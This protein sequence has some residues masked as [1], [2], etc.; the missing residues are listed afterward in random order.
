MHDRLMHD[1]VLTPARMTSRTNQGVTRL[2]SLVG[3][4]G[5]VKLEINYKSTLT[6]TTSR[7]L[8]SGTR[9]TVVYSVVGRRAEAVTGRCDLECCV[10]N[11]KYM[12]GI[13]RF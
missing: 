4:R 12:R 2:S 10:A 9:L 8:A 1:L 7:A 11:R 5:R 6:Y 3:F 13:C